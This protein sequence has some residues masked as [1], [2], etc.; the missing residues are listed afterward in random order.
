MKNLVMILVSLFAFHAHAQ[1]ACLTT[2][3]AR[4]VLLRK[5]NDI[6]KDLKSQHSVSLCKGRPNQGCVTKTD[7]MRA[8]LVSAWNDRLQ[9]YQSASLYSWLCAPGADCWVHATLTCDGQ[10][11]L[12]TISE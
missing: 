5:E 3:E 4:E 6:L 12:I 7:L 11:K 8:L 2:E 9:A 10:L 1:S